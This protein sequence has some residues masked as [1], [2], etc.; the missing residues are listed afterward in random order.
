MELLDQLLALGGRAAARAALPLELID[1]SLYQ[2]EEEESE[3][4]G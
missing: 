4:K 3:D 1:D 2:D